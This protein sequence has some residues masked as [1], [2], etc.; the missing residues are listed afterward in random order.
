MLEHY[1]TG[2]HI[3]CKGK[4]GALRRNE[5]TNGQ[6]SLVRIAR[7]ICGRRMSSPHS[8]CAAPGRARSL[9]P[10]ANNTCQ[11][12]RKGART[13]RVFCVRCARR[14]FALRGLVFCSHFARAAKG[15]GLRGPK[16]RALFFRE[17][18]GE[19]SAHATPGK[20]L[21]AAEFPGVGQC[22]GGAG[23]G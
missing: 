2:F 5:N 8:A 15:W 13:V 9:L 23:M 18:I 10:R 4:I 1:C 22:F 19:E 12:W 17:R 7:L 14:I 6:G 16:P 20:T 3:K 21:Y 11:Y